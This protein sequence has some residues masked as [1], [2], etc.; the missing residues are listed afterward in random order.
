MDDKK[1]SYWY[2]SMVSTTIVVI[3]GSISIITL[4]IGLEQE[5]SW[6]IS[7]IGGMLLC[8]TL[9]L[10]TITQIRYF[11]RLADWQMANNKSNIWAK[12]RMGANFLLALFFAVIM[13][14]IPFIGL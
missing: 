14:L 2:S 6:A 7:K 11:S 3:G 1:P 4:V 8:L 12:F 13:I 9:I 10:S 5:G